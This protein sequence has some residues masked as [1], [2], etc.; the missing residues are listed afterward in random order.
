MRPTRRAG[1]YWRTITHLRPSQLAHRVRL[2]SQQEALRRWP[3]PIERHWSLPPGP[4]QALPDAFVPV[5]AVAPP[6]CGPYAEVAAGTFTFL[7]ERR[8]LG[9]PAAWDPPGSSQLWLYHQH[10]WE[11]AWTLAAHADRAAAREVFDGQYRSWAAATRFGRWNA[12]A[13]YPASLRAWVLVNVFGALAADGPLAEPLTA[14]IRRHAA[15]VAHNLERDVGGN[16]LIKNLKALV[17]LGVFLDDTSLVD[18]ARRHLGRE[19]RHQVLADG[20]HFELSPSYH[21][22]VL[23]DLLDV[24]G[25]LAAADHPPVP[26]LDH[27]VT[28]MRRWLGLMLLPDGDVPLFNDCELVGSARLAALRP[29]PPA[30]DVLTVLAESGYVVVRPGDRIHLVADV[31]APCPDDLPAHAQADCLGFELSIDGTRVVVD[32]GTSEYGNGPR[33][34]HERSTRAHNT[35]EVDGVDQ[36]EVWGAFR[37]GRLARATLERASAS[38]QQVEVVASHDGYHHLPGTP[39]HRRRWTVGDSVV[40]IHDEITGAGSH[41][42]RHHLRLAGSAVERTNANTAEPTL[43]WGTV[44]VSGPAGS[45]SHWVETDHAVGFGELRPAW[46]LVTECSG[47]LPATFQ[48][49]IAVHP[50]TEDR[51]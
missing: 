11:W 28:A 44:E 35:V 20:G 8:A 15:F 38:P 9:E 26:G 30:T 21:C 51:G 3:D 17:G 2:R 24:Q 47:E 13:P 23:A 14:E 33:R 45:T 40:T 39:H 34:A 29:G 19:L 22:Q 5:D 50:S 36:T 1:L 42:L 49:A 12:W 6:W 4:G 16:H 31:G 18:L 43:P 25:L 10:Y 27:A 41:R 32:P 46:S 7:G 48:T 37:A